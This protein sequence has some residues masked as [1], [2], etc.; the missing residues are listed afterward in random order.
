MVVCIYRYSLSHWDEVHVFICTCQRVCVCVLIVQYLERWACCTFLSSAVAWAPRCGGCWLWWQSGSGKG[1][2]GVLWAW[3]GSGAGSE[4]ERLQGLT[5]TKWRWTPGWAEERKDQADRST[6][7]YPC[8][9]DTSLVT[10]IAS[11]I[12][13]G[14]WDD[15]WI[16]AKC[17]GG[18]KRRTLEARSSTSSILHTLLP[19]S[20]FQAFCSIAFCFNLLCLLSCLNNTPLTSSTHWGSAAC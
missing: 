10:H 19:P 20:L 2:W 12:A 5:W 3:W 13:G 17:L 14:P 8:V 18:R 15:L 16:F 9:S 4:E 11:V 7:N 6:V 1:V